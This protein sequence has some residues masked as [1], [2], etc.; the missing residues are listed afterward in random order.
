MPILPLA[1]P[2]QSNAGEQPHTGAAALI[3]AYAVPIGTE[4][5]QQVMIR[6]ASGLDAFVT[7][8]TTGGIR[9]TLEMDGL[10][11]VVAGRTLYSV[12]ADGSTA[13]LG[14]IPSDGHVG[15]ARN[16]R[17]DGAQLC[18]CSDGLAYILANGTLS[19]I[20]D[21]DLAP[22]IDVCCINQSFIFAASDGRMMR[23]DV[24]DGFDIDGLDLAEAESAP[25]ALLRV[26]DRGSDLIAIGA[27]STEVWVDQGGEAF[28]FTRAN[29]ISV[30]AVGARAVTKAAVLGEVVTDTVAWCATDARG[31]SAGV[32]MLNGYTPQKISTEYEDRLIDEVTDKTTIIA[33]SWVEQGR[34]F[35]SFRLPT[36]TLVYDTSTGKWHERRSRDDV[37]DETTW[38]VGLV[39]V[40]GG[41]VL[42]GHATEPTLY[43]L[44]RSYQD[45][46][47]EE[48]VMVIR[49]PPV[50]SFPG[51]IECNHLYLDVV[52][53]VGTTG[54]DE[55]PQI[56]MRMSRDG[57]TWGSERLRS[58]G[59]Q[60][61]RQKRVSWTAL[62]TFDQATIEFRCSAG[63][64]RE[65][66]SAQW[67]GKVLRP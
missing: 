42:A 6:A 59:K 4:R 35:I 46:D 34:A 2:F 15:M 23:S 29:V 8:E 49:T 7:F 13:L 52:P 38:R 39:T 1:L 3:N 43:W 56:A 58:V 40:L 48:M 45:E 62:G 61:Q 33:S 50:H 19:A 10:L 25:D 16:Q 32:V 5:K 44:D 30:G 53:G 12:D 27:S 60:G 9:G 41:K 18:I 31:R 55:D 22:P 36:T 11:Y 21:T 37:G 66:L 64:A 51:R 28:G 63:V 14:G 17:D 20:E 54:V 67:D 65:F 57:E 47:G 24:N 26:V